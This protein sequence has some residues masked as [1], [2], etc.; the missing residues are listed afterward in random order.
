M[1]SSLTYRGKCVWSEQPKGWS[2]EY[3]FHGSMKVLDRSG[4][5]SLSLSE[6]YNDASVNKVPWRDES[7]HNGMVKSRREAW[8]GP[9]GRNSH[10]TGGRQ[11]VASR[12]Q[13]LDTCHSYTSCRVTELTELQI[14][15]FLHKEHISCPLC[16]E[17]N[18]WDDTYENTLKATINH[19]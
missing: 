10:S 18:K 13:E 11:S 4:A 16:L 5:C 3:P 8:D 14:T 6:T 9:H 2:E 19:E 12:V 15:R 7:Q 17:G 1:V